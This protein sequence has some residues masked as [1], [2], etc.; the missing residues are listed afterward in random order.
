M[1]V[2]EDNFPKT[3]EELKLKINFIK[4]TQAD[5][6][7]FPDNQ[8]FYQT[9]R[10]LID[11]HTRLKILFA[12]FSNQDISIS[13]NNFPYNNLLKFIPEKI[14]HYCLWSCQGKLSSDKVE[15]LIK[16]KF[17]ENDYVWFENAEYVK[18]IPEV[19]HCH[20]FVEEK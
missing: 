17:P 2:S 19:W 1:I 14:T 20:I 10:N 16:I 8:L 11:K 5:N 7:R 3:W 13:R 12:T 6:F 4:S 15:E 9:Y 18:S